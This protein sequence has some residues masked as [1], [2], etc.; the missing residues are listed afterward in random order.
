[1]LVTDS[2]MLLIGIIFVASLVFTITSLLLLR[3]TLDRRVRKS[4]SSSIEYNSFY[5]SFFGLFRTSLFANASILSGK[6]FTHTIKTYYGE[7]DIH[8]FAN[9]FEKTLSGIF[10]LNGILLIAIG[11]FVPIT[12][13]L[14]IIQWP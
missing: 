11:L 5:D 1:M 13:S 12:D 8:K 3:F 6:R 2:T 7:I 9:P 4:L 14:G 10:L